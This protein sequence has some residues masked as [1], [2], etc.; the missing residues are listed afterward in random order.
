MLG[1]K[2]I[3]KATKRWVTAYKN[4]TLG[5]SATLNPNQIKTH[6]KEISDKEK[7]KRQKAKIKLLE[8]EVELLKKSN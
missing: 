5:V 1:A 6:K 7:I 4:S 8:L 3:E 2:R